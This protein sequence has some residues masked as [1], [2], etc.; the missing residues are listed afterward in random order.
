MET[1][2]IDNYMVYT[3][4][5]GNATRL[6]A[7]LAP[8]LV[9]PVP[10]RLQIIVRL[11]RLPDENLGSALAYGTAK[12]PHTFTDEDVKAILATVGIVPCHR[13]ST[14][15]FDPTSVETN[16]GG[17]CESCFHDRHPHRMGRA[18]P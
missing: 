9:T 17:L 3:R 13:C 11:Q 10:C 18:E 14:P 7:E 12:A 1:T 8:R 4:D 15:A 5:L 16:R 2:V 6:V